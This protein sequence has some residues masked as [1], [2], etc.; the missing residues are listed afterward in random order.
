MLGSAQT[1]QG[2]RP[3]TSKQLSF[4]PLLVQGNA[5]VWLPSA[6]IHFSAWYQALQPRDLLALPGG[7]LPELRDLIQQPGHQ[8]FHLDAR[9]T[10]YPG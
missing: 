5:L 8:S 9:Q 3:W 6:V 2:L 4:C 10:P 1:R 7:D